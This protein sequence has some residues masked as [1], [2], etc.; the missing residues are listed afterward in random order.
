MTTTEHYTDGI[1]STMLDDETHSMSE[2]AR[3]HLWMHFSNMGSYSSKVEVP[4]MVRGEGAWVYDSRGNRYLD[5]LS[6][7]FTNQLG[8]GRTDLAEAAARQAAQMAYFPI[9][10][11]AHPN[12][13]ELAEKLASLTPGDLNR[14]FFTTGGSEAVESAWKLARQYHR[15]RGDH[16]RYKV[17]SR[18]IAYHG[19]TMGALTITSVIPYRTPFEPLVPGA[20]KVPNTNRYRAYEHGDDEAA[21]SLWSADQIEEAILREGAETVAAVF[22]EPVQNAG[23]CFTPPVGYFQKV[24]E[25]CDRHGVLLVSDEVICAFGRIGTWF[26]GQKYDYVPDMIT[27][28]KGMTSGYAPLGALIVSDRVAAPF[29]EEENTFLHGITFAGHP[30]SCAVAL[31]SIRAFETEHV[32]E[33]VTSLEGYL[34]DQLESLREI[35]IV[36]DVRGTGY[37]WGIELVKD[38]ATRATFEGDEAE[39]LLRGF[40]SPELFKRGLI[41]RSDDRGDPVVQVAPP[42][43]CD[44]AELDFMVGT[45][46]EVLTEAAT[47]R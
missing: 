33:H 43:I 9:W 3:K 45:L 42:L 34:H 28:A 19:T 36:G 38:Q 12:A 39:R 20:I 46:R 5:G 18:D 21:F 11:Y 7:L 4:I 25:I 32:L 44:R 41:C 30:V 27:C 2:R 1:E 10:T 14:V 17:I 26:G 6:G 13:I 37:F 29:F 40:V 8:H 24:R 23:G 16:D 31:A 15:L 35:P 22:L 47:R